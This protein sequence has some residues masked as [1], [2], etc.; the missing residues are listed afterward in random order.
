MTDRRIYWARE[1][2]TGLLSCGTPRDPVI[3][4]VFDEPMDGDRPPRRIGTRV[5]DPAAPSLADLLGE[6][7]DPEVYEIVWTS[8]MAEPPAVIDPVTG[9]AVEDRSGRLRREL[10]A[11]VAAEAVIADRITRL[12]AE[13]AIFAAELAQLQVEQGRIV[14]E[15]A[16]LKAE[17]T[18]GA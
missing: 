18:G 1:K 7:A 9:L 2:A 12:S 10:E 6:A 13:P 11:V 16:R 3:E 8:N 17:I 5:L 14:S 4:D 15:R